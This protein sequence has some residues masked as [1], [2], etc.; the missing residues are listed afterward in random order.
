MTN[1]P[2][3]L[4]PASAP[5]S[6]SPGLV[7]EIPPGGAF[8]EASG[9]ILTESTGTRVVGYA[10]LGP[11][12]HTPWGIVHGGL[13]ATLVET[14]ASVGATLAVYERGQVAVGVNN[15]TDFLRSTTKGRV[16][17]LAEPIIQGRV[18]QLWQV[19]ISRADGKIVARGQVRLQNIPRPT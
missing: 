1:D 3:T 11:A 5:A 13:Y 19:T 17:L 12:H 15:S 4:E 2:A 9:L 8:V 14:A 7:A 10:E 16:D 18:Q 6:D